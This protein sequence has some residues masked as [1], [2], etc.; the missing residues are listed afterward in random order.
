M[1]RLT[2]WIVFAVIVVGLPI[3]ARVMKVRAD[4][5]LQ[6]RAERERNASQ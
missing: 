2:L 1:F 6:R 5:A 4:R 3:A